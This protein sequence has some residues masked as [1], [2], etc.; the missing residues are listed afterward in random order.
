M[1]SPSLAAMAE[2]SVKSE[3]EITPDQVRTVLQNVRALVK[4]PGGVRST[5]GASSS[6]RPLPY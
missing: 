3:G 6:I 5:H 2:G 1:V 4:Q